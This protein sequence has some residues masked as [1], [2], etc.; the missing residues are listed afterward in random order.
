MGIKL[1]PAKDRA[2]RKTYG[3]LY[4]RKPTPISLSL[5]IAAY[6]FS[7]VILYSWK[8]A[9][10]KNSDYLTIGSW[11]ATCILWIVSRRVESKAVNL[12]EF[13]LD[14]DT[15]GRRIMNITAI[16]GIFGLIGIMCFV[17]YLW[18]PSGKQIR[19]VCFCGVV[20]SSIINLTVRARRDMMSRK[21]LENI[22]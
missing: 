14:R 13:A 10:V 21:L 1:V 22:S 8:N 3:S 7:I 15:P 2:R 17:A 11:I 19:T 20:L 6:A 9:N 18:W 4:W 16:S 12:G 5:E